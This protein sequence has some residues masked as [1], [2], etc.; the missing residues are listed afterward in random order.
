LFE[1]QAALRKFN[2]VFDAL[3]ASYRIF[4]VQVFKK[5]MDDHGQPAGKVRAV[6]EKYSLG[7]AGEAHR[8]GEYIDGVVE[9]ARKGG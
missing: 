8:Y 2:M 6:L 9:K 1:S 7:V 3:G 5:C 4:D